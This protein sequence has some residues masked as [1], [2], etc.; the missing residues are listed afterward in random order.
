[1]EKLSLSKT[2]GGKVELSELRDEFHII[3]I[4]KIVCVLTHQVN[5]SLKGQIIWHNST[6]PVQRYLFLIHKGEGRQCKTVK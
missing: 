1:M 5:V 3:E 6:L 4:E 2:I